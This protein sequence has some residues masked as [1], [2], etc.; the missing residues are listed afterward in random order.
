MKVKSIDNYTFFLF[1][2][3]YC[4]KPPNRIKAP[5]II[6]AQSQGYNFADILEAQS[7]GYNFADILEAQS[8]GYNFADILEAHPIPNKNKTD[9]FKKF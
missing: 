4:V 5:P 9:N 3:E 8:Q 6:E 2:D 7:Q 1:Q